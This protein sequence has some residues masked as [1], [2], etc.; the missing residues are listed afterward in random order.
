ML[1]LSFTT[2]ATPNLTGI[3]A[4]QIARKLGYQGVDIRL[5]DCSC[6][7]TVD[8]SSKEIALLRYAFEAEGILLPSLLCYNEIPSD[9]VF[10]WQKM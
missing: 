4:I 3:E 7:L 2:M 9:D 10:S 1:K 5:S 6:E 8:S